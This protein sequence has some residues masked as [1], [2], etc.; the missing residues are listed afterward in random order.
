MQPVKR[1]EQSLADHRQSK[2]LVTRLVCL[3]DPGWWA[4]SRNNIVGQGP[5]SFEMAAP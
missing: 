2:L 1:I 5:S 4:E 3:S